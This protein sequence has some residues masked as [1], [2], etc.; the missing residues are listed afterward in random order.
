MSLS[1]PFYSRLELE[2]ASGVEGGLV[3][4]GTIINLRDAFMGSLEPVSV[5]PFTWQVVGRCQGNGKN[6]LSV[7]NQAV[8]SVF[9]TP[10]AGM[11]KAYLL[12]DPEGEFSLA[13]SEDSVTITPRFNP[14]YV[15]N[16]YPCRIRIITN[17]GVRTITLL[18]PPAITDAKSQELD[19]AL[20]RAISSC[21]YWEKDFTSVEKLRWRPDPPFGEDRFTQFWQIVVRGLQPENTIR[22]EGPDGRT[23]VTAHSSRAGVAHISLLFPGDRAPSELALELGG[24]RR[25]EGEEAREISVQQVL[26]EHRATLPVRGPLRAMR[27]EGPRLIIVDAEQDMMWDVTVPL[28]PALL[29]STAVAEDDSRDRL[30]VQSGK[31][32]G[33]TPTPNL[34]RVLERLQDRNGPVAAVGNPRVGGIAEALYVRTERGATLFD[35]ANADAPREM[36]VYE[37]PAW[38]EGVAL[39]GRL[40]AR[41]DSDLNVVEIYSATMTKTS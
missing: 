11:C 5:N 36:Q 29:R 9:G 22:V 1:P 20:L 37:M 2:T 24:G 12:S 21:Y 18:P 34:L 41:Y 28:V 17:R 23:L 8:I 15:A 6:N 4:S 7:A 35:I 27:F 38:Y 16:P 32:L 25:E 14:S 13:V 31:R 10:P 33:A 19:T 39:R 30:V 40:M 26:F 3:L